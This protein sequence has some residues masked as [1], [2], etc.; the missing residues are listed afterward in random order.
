MGYSVNLFIRSF[1]VLNWSDENTGEHSG[2]RVGTLESIKS[3]IKLFHPTKVIMCWEGKNS[4]KRR[5]ELLEEYKE[6][7]KVRRSLNR[8]FQWS[9]PEDEK[10]AFKKQLLKVKEY[11]SVMPV[12]ELE[13]ENME[14]DDMIAYV[15][16]NLWK[17]DYKIIVSSDRDYF[18]LVT[19]KVD[20]YRP[21][22]KELVTYEHMLSEYKVYPKNWILVKILTGD[23]SDSVIGFRGLGLK[24]VVKLFPFLYEE[25]HY[26]VS[27]IFEY[28]QKQVDSKNKS[29]FYQ[30]ILDNKERVE[31][32]WKVMQLLEHELPIE[33][34][35]KIDEYFKTTHPKFNAFQLRLLFLS[36][37]AEKNLQYFD[38]WCRI[39]M[40]LNWKES[41]SIN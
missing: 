33:D 38:D 14:A 26:E 8:T 9:S 37:G 41:L 31:I 34:L 17:D 1:A 4:G 22:K 19:D 3:L 12:Y 18:Q 20:V 29:R 6:G 7:R 15:S 21:V 27:D 35:R 10:I 39:M 32:N 30:E 36:D 23:D 11:L 40:P 16:N 25:K 2:G 28:C 24:T 5:R 13:Y